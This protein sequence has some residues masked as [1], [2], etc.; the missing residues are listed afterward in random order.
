MDSFRQWIIP[1][2]LMAMGVLAGCS[3]NDPSRPNDDR[4]ALV[5]VEFNN[6]SGFGQTREGYVFASDQDGRVLDC[7]HWDSTSRV[8]LRNSEVHPEYVALSLFEKLGNNV[9]LTTKNSVAVGTTQTY[10][11]IPRPEKSGTARI[12]LLHRPEVSRFM[13]SGSYITWMG[14]LTPPPSIFMDIN[15]ETTDIYAMMVPVVGRPLG[16]WVRRVRAGDVATIDFDSIVEVSPLGAFGIKL[17]SGAH[18]SYCA[19]WAEVN[20][21]DGPH[22]LM[23][24]RT[25]VTGAGSDSL[26]LYL[27][28]LDPSALSF[29]IDQ[30]YPGSTYR[31]YQQRIEGHFPGV[32]EN[33][34]GDILVESA[35]PDSVAVSASFGWDRYQIYWA[36]D[37]G[38]H[39]SWQLT[40]PALSLEWGLPEIPGDVSALFPDIQ[41]EDF[42]ATSVELYQDSP[43]GTVRSQ[44]VWLSPSL[45]VAGIEWLGDRPGEYDGRWGER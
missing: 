4:D 40:G 44:R 22:R 23:F 11:A 20:F 34:V 42:T 9:S 29:E 27:P 31:S 36:Q 39:A 45:D 17:P 28:F 6:Y 38:L 10:P 21:G 5:V 2:A 8:T 33:L 16:G 3:D 35:S 25:G 15:G 13:V 41:R 12:E 1:A 26:T 43:D 32:V 37:A 7:R 30:T 24:D 19:V 14:D 18:T